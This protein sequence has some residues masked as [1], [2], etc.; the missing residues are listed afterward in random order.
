[1]TRI[2]AGLLGFFD[3]SRLLLQQLVWYLDKTEYVTCSWLLEHT[4][5]PYK[6]QTTAAL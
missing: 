1:M 4:I 5:T 6:F 2:I 3:F